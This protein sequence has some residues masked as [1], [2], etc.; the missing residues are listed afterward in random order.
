MASFF[1]GSSK[2][3]TTV[4][5]SK[6]VESMLKGIINDARSIDDFK[7][8]P[9][10]AAT[11][12]PQQQNVIN[13]YAQSGNLRAISG[14]LAPHLTQG[15]EEATK[16]NDTYENAANNQ[17]NVNKVLQDSNAMR[18]GLY[19]GVQT[20]AASAG[21]VAGRLGSDAARAAARRGTSQMQAA[22]AIN[23]AFTDQAIKIAGQSQ[24]NT[25][26]V[27]EMQS[28]IA[29]KNRALGLQG[30]EAGNQA[31]INQL[32]GGDIMQGYQ[33][34]LFQNQQANQQGQNDFVWNKIVNK[35]SIMSAV[36]PMAGY[37][38]TQVG[39]APSQGRQ[40]LG[41][42]IAGLGMYAKYNMDKTSQLQK[43]L[44]SGKTSFDQ[45]ADRTNQVDSIGGIPVYASKP[46][47][48][49]TT[50][51]FLSN[52]WTGAKGALAG[53]VGG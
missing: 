32:S 9:H 46:Q 48:P 35:Q 6:Q 44:N 53:M 50:S 14:A 47:T 18:S 27:A 39:S 51:G 10:E 13:Q 12:T 7:F 23:P 22:S 2:T 42:G 41:A 19:K 49:T 26:D 5:P 36:S 52:A 3:T 15:I 11:M 20:T 29:A 4:R 8:I 21:N 34:S 45:L 24:R 28:D 43:D 17:I 38:T 16:L 40:L 37:T 31:M 25:L 30:V 1:G 33:N